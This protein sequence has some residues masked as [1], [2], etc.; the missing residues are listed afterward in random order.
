M[1]ANLLALSKQGNVEAIA[2]L[3][4]R[5]LKPRGI[6]AKVLLKDTCLKIMLEAGDVPDQQTLAP[7]IF[8]G[9]SNLSIPLISTIQVY[10]RQKGEKTPVWTQTFSPSSA[11][12]DLPDFVPDS[13]VKAETT[14]ASQGQ[15]ANLKLA[16]QG[17]LAALEIA[18]NQFVS[19]E[20][21]KIKLEKEGALL[22]VIAETNK[23]LDGPS[24]SK[25]IHQELLRLNLEQIET[26]EIYKQKPKGSYSL[27]LTH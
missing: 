8:N 19:D 26:V 10:G 14:N 13:E 25:G 16:S 15:T 27:E 6:T 20:D 22:K 4:N 3:I 7:F 12:F 23:F 1:Q 24:F 11:E 17:N 5:S 18:L 21:I 9:V 2:A